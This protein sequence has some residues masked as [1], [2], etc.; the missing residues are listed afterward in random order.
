MRKNA[1]EST[2]NASAGFSTQQNKPQNGEFDEDLDEDEKERRRMER[3]E[4]RRR[5]K[6]VE[7]QRRQQSEEAER[8]RREQEDAKAEKDRIAKLRYGSSK[9]PPSKQIWTDEEVPEDDLEEDFVNKDNRVEPDYEI[10]YKQSVSAEDV[11]LG[12][13]GKDPSSGSCNELVVRVTM[14]GVKFSSIDLQVTDSKMYVTSPLHKLFLYLPH[15][16]KSDKGTAKWNSAKSQLS[17]I[18]PTVQT[19]D[20]M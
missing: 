2:T 13:S 10:L 1:S 4:Q 14:P 17:V 6:E 12:L 15:R 5:I 8:L 20:L 11:Y 7:E 19:N 3:R 9:V 18:L 16:V